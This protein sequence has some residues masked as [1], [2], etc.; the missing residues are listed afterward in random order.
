MLDTAE[1]RSHK[2]WKY[3]INETDPRIG[4]L[5]LLT[6]SAVAL[7]AAIFL[8]TLA[9]ISRFFTLRRIW[10]VTQALFGCSM[11]ATLMFTSTIGLIPLFSLVGIHWAAS[12]WIPFALLGTELSS[13]R[14]LSDEFD[15]D[16]KYQDPTAIHG[17]YQS[18]ST[19][20]GLIY[21]LHNL[22]ICLPQILVTMG[23]GVVSIASDLDQ[24]EETWKL[25]WILRL[26]GMFS[27]VAMYLATKLHD[28]Y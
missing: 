13:R 20:P 27:F 17:D 1:I 24:G 18:F 26:G 4:S 6:F 9:S 2:P 25:A 22:C 3:A 7:F 5:V 8:P 21:G 10:I 12:N 11:L 14:Q 28:V 23:M 16:E 15:D 19:H